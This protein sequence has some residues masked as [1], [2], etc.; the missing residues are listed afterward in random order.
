MYFKTSVH[1][2]NKKIHF[3]SHTIA[4]ASTTLYTNQCTIRI[5]LIG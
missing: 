5:K 2:D 1:V 4:N 3:L